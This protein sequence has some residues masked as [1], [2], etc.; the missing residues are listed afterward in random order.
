VVGYQ[1][2]GGSG[3]EVAHNERK[4][5]GRHPKWVG[6]PVPPEP[7]VKVRKERLGQGFRPPSA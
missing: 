1:N 6:E 2:W 7:K 4:E 5:G 3:P